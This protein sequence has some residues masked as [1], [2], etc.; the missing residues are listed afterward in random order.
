MNKK[1]NLLLW[2]LII[3]SVLVALA[4]GILKYGIFSP[5]GIRTERSIME[6]PFLLK[7]YH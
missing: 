4:G 7:N 1:T 3:T 5:L 6:L 2:L